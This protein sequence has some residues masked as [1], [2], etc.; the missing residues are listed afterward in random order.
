[1]SATLAV[2]FALAATTPAPHA[3]VADPSAPPQRAAEPVVAC[4]AQGAIQTANP[5]PA[6]LYRPDGRLGVARLAQLP[7]PDHEK[8]VVRSV[9]GC[10]APLVVGY[11]V[12]R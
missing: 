7:R 6:L 3:S 9:D 1:M 4:R 8:A 2:V 11:G 5:E 10:A 12:G